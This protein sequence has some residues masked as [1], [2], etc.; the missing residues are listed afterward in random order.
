MLCVFYVCDG[1][2]GM[3]DRCRLMVLSIVSRVFSVGLLFGDSV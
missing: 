2:V 3:M 1:C